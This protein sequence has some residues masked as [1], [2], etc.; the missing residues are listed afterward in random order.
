MFQNLMDL[1]QGAGSEVFG[2]WL[3]LP[4]SITAS[5]ERPDMLSTVLLILAIWVVL[6]FIVSLPLARMMH[7]GSGENPE[8]SQRDK[9]PALRDDDPALK[10][11]R[12]SRRRARAEL[13]RADLSLLKRQKDAVSR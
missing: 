10:G 6:S 12:R 3:A 13:R 11:R 7:I 1:Q 4:N 2:N 8:S 9:E 5:Q